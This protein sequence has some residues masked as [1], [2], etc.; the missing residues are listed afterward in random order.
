[1]DTTK[2]DKLIYAIL[3][4]DV[5]EEALYQIRR[6]LTDDEM[7]LFKKRLE[8]AIGENMLLIY[9]AIFKEIRKK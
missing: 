6:Y 5:Q 1:M 8:Y 4:E 2:K 3:E 7:I 9:P